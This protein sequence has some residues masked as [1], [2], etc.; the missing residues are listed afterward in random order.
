MKARFFIVFFFCIPPKQPTPQITHKNARRTHESTKAE[1]F[2][3][4]HHKPAHN[5]PKRAKNNTPP[6]QP[7]APPNKKADRPHE[8]S[9][10]RH[11]TSQARWRGVSFF[12]SLGIV[13][14]E[15]CRVELGQNCRRYCIGVNLL[16]RNLVV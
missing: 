3:K 8:P 1:Q 10:P 4:P 7:P 12:L 9:R 13:N 15:N 5:S 14:G 11:P 2:I 6:K 16:S